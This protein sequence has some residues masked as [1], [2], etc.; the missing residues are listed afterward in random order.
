MP[1]SD[2]I[3][4]KP[5]FKPYNWQ[6][7]AID[8]YIREDRYYFAALAEM[9]TGKT[10]FII[11]LLRLLKQNEPNDFCILIIVPGVAINNWKNEINQFCIEK[12]ELGKVF[13]LIEASKRIETIVYARGLGNFVAITNYES[14]DNDVFVKEVVK[15]HFDVIVCDEMHRIKNY[16]SKRAKRIVDISEN[17]RYRFGMTGTPILNSPMDLFMQWKFLDKG[18]AFGKNFFSFR[19]YYF[20]DK[21]NRWAGRPGYFPDF[22]P[23]PEKFEELS[24]K[25]EKNSVRVLSKDVLK[26]LPEKQ[27]EKV[28]LKMSPKQEK[29]YQQMLK[30]LVVFME[31]GTAVAQ[32]AITKALRLM[33]IASGFIT[34]DKNELVRFDNPKIDYVEKILEDN[35]DKKT[36]IWCSFIENYKTICERLDKLKIKHVKITGEEN[37]K[38]KSEANESFQKDPSVLV[39]V[40]NRKAGGIAINLTASNLSIVYSRNFSR[41]DEEQSWYRNL[42]GGSEIHDEIV[43]IDLI[44][45]N[46]IEEDVIEA[47]RNK[48]E[49]SDI[50]IDLKRN[51][52]LK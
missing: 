51:S 34:T 6:D 52:N 15:C 20:Y 2:Y 43:N 46:T 26:H 5:G 30:D 31:E 38:E 42:R 27:N 37:I 35:P 40:C 32:L 48:K 28:F 7:A 17:I 18:E 41:E 29:A 16:K 10:F 14:F 25:I 49:I 3:E 1:I 47:L 12:D 9:G 22:Q 24:S 13:P 11:C 21:N 45:E 8:K 44:M 23:I 33:Q 4:L 19:N 39:A 50:I 36:I